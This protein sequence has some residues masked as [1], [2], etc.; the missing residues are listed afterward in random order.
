MQAHELLGR[1]R[2]KADGFLRATQDGLRAALGDTDGFS[3]VFGE[4][5][6][7]SEALRQAYE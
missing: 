6:N 5:G 3:R 7:L 1:A 2:A 4:I